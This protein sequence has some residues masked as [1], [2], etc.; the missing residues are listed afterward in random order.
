VLSPADHFLRVIDE[1]RGL[2]ATARAL[3]A[4]WLPVPC[5]GG[6]GEPRRFRPLRRQDRGNPR[7]SPCPGP[8][9]CR[10]PCQVL[11]H[12]TRHR[13]CRRRSGRQDPHAP[14]TDEAACTVRCRHDG[15][16]LAGKAEQ[17]P[18][19][20]CPAWRRW[21]G[22]KKQ[23]RPASASMSFICP[24]TMPASPEARASSTTSALRMAGSVIG[25]RRICQGSR[26]QRSEA[27]R[28]QGWRSPRR[29]CGASSAARAAG[30]HCPWPGRSSCTRE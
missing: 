26:R 19:L 24:P 9:P 25:C 1:A 2:G 11:R 3:V 22:M 28:L 23:S 5:N 10:W 7:R 30:R 17:G 13:E 18:R 29:T 16:C 21:L 20:A 27:R 8:C 12:P 4:I 14:H 6:V 15:A